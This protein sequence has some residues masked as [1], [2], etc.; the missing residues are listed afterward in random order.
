[1]SRPTDLGQVHR[2]FLSALEEAWS[3]MLNNL[4]FRK[5]DSIQCGIDISATAEDG[6]IVAHIALMP[7]DNLVW[8]W[9]DRVH[10]QTDGFTGSALPIVWLC[11][12]DNPEFRFDV[13]LVDSRAQDWRLEQAGMVV[14]RYTKLVAEHWQTWSQ[15]RFPHWDLTVQAC[16]SSEMVKRCEWSRAP[17]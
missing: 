11:I 7:L 12:L 9:F 1:M 6:K 5:F 17:Q 4:G 3:P 8:A 2:E 16:Q 14:R 15:L 10:R 13:R